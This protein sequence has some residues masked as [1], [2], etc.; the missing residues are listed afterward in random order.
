[1]FPN[2]SPKIREYLAQRRQGTLPKKPRGY[3]HVY[4]IAKSFENFI[5]YLEG[6]EE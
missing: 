3:K 4:Q 5:G 6:A 2:L 1:M